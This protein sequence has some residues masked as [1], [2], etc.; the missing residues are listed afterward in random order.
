MIDE[1]RVFLRF[2]EALDVQIPSGAFDRLQ[3]ALVQRPVRSRRRPRVAL[4]FQRAG[5][6]VAAGLIAVLLVVALIAAF[7]A[8]HL[9][10]GRFTPVKPPPHSGPPVTGSGATPVLAQKLFGSVGWA[11]GPQ[12]TTDGGLHWRDV[13]PPMPA[14][15]AEGAS[16]SYFLDANHAWVTMATGNASNLNTAKQEATRLVIFGTS[17]GGHTWTQGAVAITGFINE[18]AGLDFIDALHGWLITDTGQLAIGKGNAPLPPQ[19]ITRAIYATA[20]G[21]LTWSQLVTGRQGDGS[22]L[23]NQAMGCPMSG[24]TFASSRLGWLTWDC[25][26]SGPATNPPPSGSMVA[27]T[28]DGGR[29]WQTIQLPSFP[30]TSD[31]SCGAFPPVL[32]FGQ[33]VLP[34]SCGGIGR[35]GFDAVYATA[36]SGRTWT[37]RKLPFF[38]GNLDFVDA[39]TGYTF[40]SAG[41]A[42]YRTTDGGASWT[43][44][45]RFTS[46]QYVDGYAFPGS[47]SGFVLTSR[48]TADGTSGYSTFWKSTDGGKTWSVVSSVKTGPRGI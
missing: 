43:V 25:F 35:P 23:G 9:S 44:L 11:Q 37:F 24:I 45:R 31:F 30:T 20:D 4:P 5:F 48:Y 32:T 39:N 16:A 8:I 18:S 1:Q 38:G 12:R 34:A 2:H 10:T 47:T 14:N 26:H 22:T 27:A 40:S 42:L 17:D 7:L 19:P 13:S 15:F 36:D 6:R 41:V 21:G 33:G 28:Q 3:T 46:E 29:S